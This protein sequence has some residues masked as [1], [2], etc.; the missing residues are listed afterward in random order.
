MEIRLVVLGSGQDGGSP[1][2]GSSGFRGPERTASSVALTT[3]EG[4]ALLFDASPDLRT[5]YQCLPVRTG[6]AG[7]FDAVF[8]THAHTGHYTGLVHFGKEAAAA[9]GI[10]LFAPDSVISYLEANQPWATLLT[11][12]N[13]DAIPLDDGTATVDGI[14]VE[15]IPVPHRAEFSS[16]V[17]YS[18]SVGGEPW[19]L[20][21]PDIDSWDLWPD[22]EE[23]IER[24]EVC[25][26]DAAFA[27]VDELPNRDL[28]EIPHPL[29]AD[30]IAR[31]G[32]LTGSRRLV[33]THI[34]HTNEV[35]DPS[36]PTALRASAAG[37]LVAH[38]GMVFVHEGPR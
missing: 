28:T 27:S 20:Y 24:H 13:L 8:I 25:L 38:D 16:T 10:P 1:Q 37:F 26:L 22:A 15:A 12:G 36:S 34:N 35:A 32:H 23:Q 6:S 14:S 17:A 19:V 4:L 21:L 3:S 2:L 9:S 5:Q 31:F 29:V 7:P 30:T 18:V 11:D 33:L